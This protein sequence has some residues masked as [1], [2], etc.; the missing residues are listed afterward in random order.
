MLTELFFLDSTGCCIIEFHFYMQ[1]V[2]LNGIALKSCSDHITDCIV[3]ITEIRY[4][5][6]FF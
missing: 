4:E 3:D 1:R 2:Q 5:C 6:Y